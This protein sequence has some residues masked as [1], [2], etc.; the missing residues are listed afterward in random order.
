M[1]IRLAVLSA[2]LLLGL[3]R[4]PAAFGQSNELSILA[5]AT[6]HSVDVSILSVASIS[7]GTSA[8]IQVDFAH[9]LKEGRSGTLY[10]ELPAA[11]VL[12]ASVGIQTGRVTAGTSQFFFTPGVRYQFSP[13]SRISP[14]LAAGF[15]FG[16]FD[17]ANIVVSGPVNVNVADGFQP[18]AGFGGGAEIR[19]R[20]GFVFRAEVRDYVA[21]GANISSRNHVVYQ[22]GFGFHF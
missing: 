6:T 3:I 10:L 20:R 22:G 11:R 13:A 1:Q 16:W 7:A 9:R 19:I 2:P 15:G 18:A 4:P 5:G 21:C 8:A 14:Y 12:K 17:R